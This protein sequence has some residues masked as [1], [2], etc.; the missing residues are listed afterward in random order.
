MATDSTVS[1]WSDR[2]PAAIKE[3]EGWFQDT[4]D[5]KLA[6]L[7]RYES[8]GSDHILTAGELALAKD[9]C[10]TWELETMKLYGGIAQQPPSAL[11]A[12]CEKVEKLT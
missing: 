6:A 10:E 2:I 4:G 9:A 8:D 12:F 5:D 1:T 7:W 3:A 11:I